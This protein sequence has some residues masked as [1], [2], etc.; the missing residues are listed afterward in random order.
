MWWMKEDLFFHPYSK[1]AACN[2]LKRWWQRNKEQDKSERLYD[3]ENK[4]IKKHN[5][6]SAESER[7]WICQ[8]CFYMKHIVSSCTRFP[9]P[10]G[11]SV[12]FSSVSLSLCR[13]HNLTH[14]LK[15]NVQNIF[16]LRDQWVMAIDACHAIYDIQMIRKW[17]LYTN[18]IAGEHFVL[19]SQPYPC[20]LF[21]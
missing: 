1:I 16:L 3:V 13:L 21:K 14:N 10:R 5:V 12:I 20:M 11:K 15:H 2:R 19:P 7:Q 18:H 9:W 8:L 4:W 17:L 6:S